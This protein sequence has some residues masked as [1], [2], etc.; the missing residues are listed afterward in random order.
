MAE[1]Y[2]AK[3]RRLESKL[4]LRK[5]HAA[6]LLVAND[7]NE[8]GGETL[9][10]TQ[11]ADKVGVTRKTLWKWR[12]RDKDF[13]NYVNFLA[14][15]I[16]DA[17]RAFVYKQLMKLIGSSQ[18]S[19]KAIQLYLQKHGLLTDR[20]SIEY[21][22]DVEEKSNDDIRKDLDALDELLEEGREVLGGDDWNETGE[23]DGEGDN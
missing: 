3:K 12:N 13:I 5:R 23:D 4:D 1:S 14:D 17:K 2:I 10:Y 21:T 20:K 22:G 9:N 7:M 6:L 19:V 15:D 18:P 8:L 11:I 16:L